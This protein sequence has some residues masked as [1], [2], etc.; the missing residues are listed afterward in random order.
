MTIFAPSS[1]GDDEFNPDVIPVLLFRKNRSVQRVVFV[2]S[3]GEMSL[4]S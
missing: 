1:D 2:D 4:E 3:I